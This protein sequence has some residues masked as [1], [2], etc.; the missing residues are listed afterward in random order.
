MERFDSY[1]LFEQLG[2][3]ERGTVQRATLAAGNESAR[4]IAIKRLPASAL[5]AGVAGSRD[6]MDAAQ[7][8]QLRHPN[9]GRS[10]RSDKCTSLARRAPEASALRAG[11]RSLA[12]VHGNRIYE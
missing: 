10:R 1:L 7:V 5:P 2:P 11:K 8:S 4:A 9:S 12:E 6:A 3:S